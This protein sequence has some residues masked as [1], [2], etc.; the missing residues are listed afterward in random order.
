MLLK[1]K[2][3]VHVENVTKKEEEII[4][5]HKYNPSKACA[6]FQP[7]HGDTFLISVAN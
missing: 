6:Q 5:G 1:K 4:N 7:P 3:G 2:T